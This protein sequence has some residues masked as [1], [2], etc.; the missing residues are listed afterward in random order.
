MELVLYPV[1]GIP[2]GSVI[3]SSLG[4][5]RR[6][7]KTASLATRFGIAGGL[8]PLVF[9]PLA[10]RLVTQQIQQIS[11]HNTA[12]VAALYVDIFFHP[13]VKDHA[14]GI[15]PS[16]GTVVGPPGGAARHADGATA[17]CPTRSGGSAEWGQRRR[18]LP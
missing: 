17:S 10:G 9:F 8:V 3:M 13:P 1:A 16:S 5:P 15:H 6:S 2:W 4:C 14:S 7:W 18:I 11:V 12:T